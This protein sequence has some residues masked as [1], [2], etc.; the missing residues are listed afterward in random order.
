[1]IR[2]DL[3]LHT[4][5]SDGVMSPEL[6]CHECIQN[7]LT[8]IAVTD[9]DTMA[10]SDSLVS[11]APPVVVIPAVEMSMEDMPGLHLLA[12]GTAQGNM[13]RE[14]LSYLAS[15]REERAKEMIR[16]LSVLGMKLS[17]RD[18]AY[19][20]KLEGGQDSTIGR[21]HIAR[22]LVRAGYCKS[23]QEAFAKYIGN[24][25]PAYVPSVRMAIRDAI[26]LVNASG[27][28][29]VLAHPRE[30]HLEEQVLQGF[31]DRLCDLG[32]RGLEVY[33]PS[34]SSYGYES[35]RH[36]AEE[37][38]LLVTGGSDFHQ[39]NDGKHG[40]IGCMMQV[41][42]KC[43]EDMSQFQAELLKMEQTMSIAESEVRSRG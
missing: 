26:P 1:M 10:G 11:M 30:L 21:P 34:A 35:L 40:K 14:K 31:L 25:K 19:K 7:G 20:R 16:K 6:L 28:I 12:Y 15:M 8:Y 39:E 32:L 3:H 17:Y 23:M 5:R 9:H 4:N 41:W 38:H 24:N 22:A 37:R 33:H 42:E 13:L 2:A 43:T 36:M 27:F 18:L 29:P